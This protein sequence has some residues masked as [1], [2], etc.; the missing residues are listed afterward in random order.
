MVYSS[1]RNALVID[2]CKSPSEALDGYIWE[3]SKWVKLAKQGNSS[4]RVIP[5]NAPS[6][7]E[8]AEMLES[9]LRVLAETVVPAFKEKEAKRS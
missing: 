1:E 9:R 5:V 6:S 8:F 3:M 4:K 7:P 2:D